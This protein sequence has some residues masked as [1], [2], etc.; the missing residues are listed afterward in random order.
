MTGSWSGQKYARTPG[1][2]ERAEGTVRLNL[3]WAAEAAP[4]SPSGRGSDPEGAGS[5]AA[6][7]E[8]TAGSPRLKQADREKKSSQQ[9][10]FMRFLHILSHTGATS[11]L[12]GVSNFRNKIYDTCCVMSDTIEIVGV[13]FLQSDDALCFLLCRGLWENSQKFFAYIVFNKID[14]HPNGHPGIFSI[15]CLT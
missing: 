15:V 8:V 12:W 6:E 7:S 13:W 2:T 1:W 9:S 11:S 4:S 5:P 14:L 10:F 3:C